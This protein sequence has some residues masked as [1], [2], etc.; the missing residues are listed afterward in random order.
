M[1]ACHL[2]IAQIP[3]TILVLPWL[4]RINCDQGFCIK[5]A[6]CNNWVE[7]ASVFTNFRFALSVLSVC[8]HC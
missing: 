4:A 8:R 5:S 1:C 7:H 2:L 6:A 3:L